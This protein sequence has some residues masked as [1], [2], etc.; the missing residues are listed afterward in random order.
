MNAD[1]IDNEQFLSLCKYFEA[2]SSTMTSFKIMLNGFDKSHT[3]IKKMRNDIERLEE[4]MK[5][6]NAG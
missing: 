2:L 4:L 1:N 5:L 6:G 3:E